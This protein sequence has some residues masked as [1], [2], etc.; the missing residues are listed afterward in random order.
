MSLGP[1]NLGFIPEFEATAVHANGEVF[2][3]RL[4]KTDGVT[5][6]S[7][8]ADADSPSTLAVER[9]RRIKN[10]ED[11]GRVVA[12]LAQAFNALYGTSY[13]VEEKPLE[14]SDYEDR[15]LLS[16]LD[17]PSSIIVQVR[18]LDE[19]MIAGLGKKRMFRGARTGD[20]LVAHID[21]AIADKASVDAGLKSRTILLLWLPAPIGQLA[22]QAVQQHAFDRRGF[23]EIWISPFH[24]DC[25]RLG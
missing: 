4:E 7:L 21:A 1:A 12:S 6:A 25:F 13:T 18:N 22:K 14:D 23:R 10:F 15:V 20:D 5:T 9:T 17:K 8:N 3:Q 19:E 24:E 11:E 16:G 2:A